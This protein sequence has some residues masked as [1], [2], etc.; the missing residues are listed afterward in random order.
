[1]AI[2]NL[3]TYTEV[4]V[5][6]DRIQKSASRVTFTALKRDEAVYLYDDKG[7]NHF[8][9]DFEHLIDIRLTASDNSGQTGLW[10]ITNAT[11]GVAPIYTA[12]GS[13]LS[14]TI[15]RSG[16]G[17]SYSIY[18]YEVDSGTVYSDK[19]DGAELNTT[20]YLRI[21]RDESA[22]TYGTLYCDIY[23]TA[24]DRAAET[25]RLDRLSIALH[26]SKKDFQ[27]I[28]PCISY[29][30]TGDYAQSGY[31][32]NLDLQEGWRGKFN[33]VTNPAK[34][35]GIS[36]LNIAKVNGVASS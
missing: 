30:S 33:G 12:S 34:I 18:L 24:A 16:D 31:S 36:V 11:S 7:L 25:N 5:P 23:P 17:A 14:L 10:A 26:S 8:S 3:T 9:G 22:G 28:F 6:A 20:Y 15:F 27:Y 21:K 29:D 13:Y 19:W 4:D 1:M 35:N 32:E 2:E